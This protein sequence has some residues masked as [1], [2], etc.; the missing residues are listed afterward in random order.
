VQ[1]ILIVDDNTQNIY[2]LEVMLK[3]YGFAVRT[4]ENGALALASARLEPPDL[5]IAD[6]L[7]PVMDGF[8]LCR[9]WRADQTLKSIPFIFYTATYTDKKDEQLALSLGADRFVIKPQ[10]PEVLLTI[11][12]EVL[13]SVTA[14]PE[15]SSR[16]ESLLLEEYNEVLFRKLEKK[17]ADLERANMALQES[18]TRYRSLFRNSPAVMLLVNGDTA[19]VVD[20]NPA[21]QEYYG[22]DR[23]ELIRARIYDLTFSDKEETPASLA[24]AKTGPQRVE[25]KHRL[26]NGDARDVE[27]YRG[28]L[29]INNQTYIFS[30]IHDITEQRKLEHQLRQSQKMEALGQL[31]SGIAHDFNNM[32]TVI[33]GRGSMLKMRNDLNVLQLEE[34]DQILAAAEKASH[35]TG[36][37]LA[38]CRKQPFILQTTNLNDIVHHS[39]KF[40]ARVIGEDVNLELIVHRTNLRVNVDVN[41]IELVLINLATNARDAMPLGGVMTIETG[42]QEID[43]TFIHAHGYGEEGSY[44]VITISDTGCGMNRETQQKIFEPFFT[45]KETGKGTGLGL[46]IVYGIVKQHKGFINIY[47]EPGKGSTFCFYLP[48]ATVKDELP[49][50]PFLSTSPSGGDEVIL[51]AEDEPTVREMVKSILTT[52]GYEVIMAADGK[53]AVQFFSMNRD[54]IRLVLMDMIM[55]G[56]NGLEAA[57]EIRRQRHDVRILFSSGYTPDFIRKHTGDEQE[58]ELIKKPYQPTDLLRKIREVLDR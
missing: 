24:E 27:I 26:K 45:T 44:A 13:D 51:V 36:G 17:V 35:L 15:N 34:I 37:L 23:D 12:R 20:A 30:I 21:A 16:N 6:I 58:M 5:V 22:Y 28:P 50:L 42:I 57:E 2:F 14:T 9:E 32:L 19:E 11:I 29:E 43:S 38:F 49:Q 1:S 10:E 3:G 56:Q 48:L 39:Q 54:R 33:T 31:A 4:A 46:A 53:E 52:Y 47:S 41:Q 25:R 7:M 55:P 8:V 40:L 18:E